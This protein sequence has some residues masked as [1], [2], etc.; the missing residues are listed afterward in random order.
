MPD[1]RPVQGYRLF[2]LPA[3]IRK[4]GM[5]MKKQSLVFG[6]LVMALVLGLVFT[7]CG[8]DEN[9]DPSSPPGGGGGGDSIPTELVG[10]WGKEVS[11][12]L[13]QALFVINAN[14][15]GTWGDPDLGGQ[16]CS[17]SVSGNKLT[18]YFGGQDGTIDWAVNSGKL[19][20]TGTAS[21]ALGSIWSSPTMLSPLDKKSN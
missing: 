19:E 8:D 4:R 7:G 3:G 2:Y 12:S 5:Y 14:G 11:P 10:T 6:V 21:G 13:Y 15:T 16:G 18:L 9:G 20:L 17:W 1:F